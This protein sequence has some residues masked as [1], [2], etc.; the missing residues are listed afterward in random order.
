MARNSLNNNKRLSNVNLI[1]PV[2]SVQPISNKNDD[3]PR[4]LLDMMHTLFDIM[5]DDKTGYVRLVDIENRWDDDSSK[6]LPRGFI[7][8]LRKVTPSSG[9]ISF[10]RFC[11][12]LKLCLLQN[13]GSRQ[14]TTHRVPFNQTPTSHNSVMLNQTTAAIRP[15]VQPP[16]KPPRSLAAIERTRNIN[17]YYSDRMD[18]AEIRNALH[19]WQLGVLQNN[20]DDKEKRLYPQMTEKTNDTLI[21]LNPAATI[22]PKSTS[23]SR[24]PRRHTLQ[25]GVDASMIKKLKQLEQ[26]KDILL[27]GLSAIEKTREW[28]LGQIG[29]LQEKIKYLGRLRPDVSISYRTQFSIIN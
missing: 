22:G 6:G 19:N 14:T 8:C 25:D 21:G 4:Q 5:D 28:Y 18:K 26:E 24:A 3:L 29:V 7:H 2:G 16:P 10:D 9:L 11:S 12:G 23:R 20:T 15:L 17:N 27:Q 13:N 1:P